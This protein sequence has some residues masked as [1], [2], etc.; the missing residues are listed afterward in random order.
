MTVRIAM[1]NE[2]ADSR[3]ILSE[4]N[5]SSSLLFQFRPGEAIYN[6]DSGAETGNNRFQ[7]FW[8]SDE[9]ISVYLDAIRQLAYSRN[10]VPERV[11]IIFDGSKDADVD[12]NQ[13]L[14]ALLCASD[15]PIQQFATIWLGDP[16]SL[17]D[18]TNIQ[19]RPRS[20][21]NL[22]II[23]EDEKVATGL[24]TIALFT[25]AVQHSPSAVRFYIID[26]RQDTP[27]VD[28]LRQREQQLPHAVK[29][30]NRRTLSSLLTEISDEIEDRSE[31]D[32]HQKPLICLLIYGLHRIH[33][34]RSEEQASSSLSKQF[35]R[36]VR[37]GPE[38]G[39]HTLIWCDMLSNFSRAVERNVLDEFG[40]RIAFQMSENDS[41]KLVGSPEASQLGPY[42]ALLF[43]EGLSVP[44]KFIP[45]EPPSDEWLTQA[46]DAFDKRVRAGGLG[47]T[48][49]NTSK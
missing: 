30:A 14:N 23:N 44:E 31:T 42:R 45:Y 11:Q 32:T 33:A 46:V 5:T 29:V 26:G 24:L 20:G 43:K 4:D 8:L 7:T 48:Q 2:K 10:Y 39:I 13:T 19:L 15:W 38:Q 3:L 6:A 9:E 37:D 27:Y 47:G 41:T 49:P 34:L 35:A 18:T 22:L 40:L 12:E 21:S 1:R 16:I 17:K 25:L 28:R 36:I